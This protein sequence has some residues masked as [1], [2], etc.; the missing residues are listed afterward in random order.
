MVGSEPDTP[1]L[2]LFGADPDGTGTARVFELEWV[3]SDQLVRSD[4]EV[5][6]HAVGIVAEPPAER[7]N[8]GVGSLQV[9][10]DGQHVVALPIDVWCHLE[11][12]RRIA[13]VVSSNRPNS[14]GPSSDCSGPSPK[15]VFG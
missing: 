10:L 8:V 6:P 14:S 3:V 11:R 7:R 4:V 9:H 15:N 1:N 12:E 2:A 13:T 5:A